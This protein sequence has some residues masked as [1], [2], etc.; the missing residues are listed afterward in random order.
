MDVVIINLLIGIPVFLFWRWVFKRY[1]KTSSER[2]LATWVTTIISTPIVYVAII[3]LWVF[4]IRYFPSHRFSKQK[5]ISDNEKRYELSDDI[6]NS[7][8]LI[9]KSKAEVKQILGVEDNSEESNYW[10]YYLGFRPGLFNIDEDVLSIEFKDGMV[11][12]V[13]QH[14]T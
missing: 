4:S 12:N 8:T 3:M 7:R 1:I 10:T 6:I 14:E 11:I 2:K 9:G 13:S 5:W